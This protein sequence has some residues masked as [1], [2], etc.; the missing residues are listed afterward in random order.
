MPVN[1][2]SFLKSA[3]VGGTASVVVASPRPIAAHSPHK[4]DTDSRFT[5][6]WQSYVD[7]G[8]YPPLTHLFLDDFYIDKREGLRRMVHRPTALS[9]EAPV[10]KAEKEWEG[11]ALVHR[12][13]PII[14]DQH[15]K[16][17][18]FWYGCEDP[19]MPEIPA[20]I[21]R[22]WA[23]ATSTDGVHWERPELALVEF[24]GSKKN[25]LVLLQN[26]EASIALLQNVVRDDRDPSPQRRYKSIGLDRHP[27]RPGEITWTE[28]TGPTKWY[29]EMGSKIGSGLFIAYS[30]D[31]VRWRMKEGWAGSAALIMDGSALHGYDERISRWVLW[32]RPRVMPKYRTIGVSFSED[33]EHWTWPQYGIAPDKDDPPG[34]QFDHLTSIQA[35]EGYIGLLAVSGLSGQGFTAAEELPQLVYSRDGRVWTR[36]SRE[37]FLLNGLEGSWNDGPLIPVSPILVGDEVFIFYYGKNKG[38]MWGQPTLDGRRVTT[39][40]LGL[41]KLKRD[42]WVSISSTA[43]GELLTALV[44]FAHNELHVNVDAKGGTLR[45]ELLNHLRQPIPGHTLS[46][47]DPITVDSLDQVVTWKGKRDLSSLIGTARCQPEVGRALRLRFQLE[48]A[49]LYSFSC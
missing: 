10:L 11:V 34:M 27:L 24:K 22:R 26:V 9:V 40:A 15:E 21:K 48:R 47:C 42:R 45:V 8:I 19:T 12:C 46:D 35:P 41:A 23:Y 32:Q 39:S 14:Y 7:S 20:R 28:P 6:Q 31:G 1:R 49:H 5:P 4:E 43:A 3:V 18:K 16:R 2:R 13:N 44:S 36:V 29:E 38:E 17:F 25:N 37:P 33:F 30:P